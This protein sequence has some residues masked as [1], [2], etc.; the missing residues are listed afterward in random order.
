M[1]ADVSIGMGGEMS[2][3][4]IPRAAVQRVGDRT[5]VYVADPQQQGRFIEREVRLGDAIG[6]DVVVVSGVQVGDRIVTDGSFSVRAERDRLG[7]SAATPQPTAGV[8]PTSARPAEGP[9]SVQQA[10]ILL[11]EKGYE[12]ARLTLR[13]GTPVKIT[14]VRTT[15]KT[16]GTEVVFPSLNIRRALPLN[17]PVAIELTPKASG[18]IGFVCGI[19][20][21]R[22]TIVVE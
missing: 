18:E 13:A 4:R 11:T 1:F 9:S 12:P 16:C 7:I 14:F 10:K 15:D 5:V 20:M 8:A 19:N 22:G 17:Q 6:N 2:T 21:L 3:T